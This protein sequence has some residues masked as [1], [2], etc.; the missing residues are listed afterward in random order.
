MTRP[1]MEP[2]DNAWHFFYKESSI[3]MDGIASKYAN[4]LVRYPLFDIG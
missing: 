3:R 1:I 4:P 2:V